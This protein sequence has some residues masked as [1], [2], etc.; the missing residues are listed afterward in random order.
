MRICI[1]KSECRTEQT[2]WNKVKRGT[3]WVCERV[4]ETIRNYWMCESVSENNRYCMLLLY[5][6]IHGALCVY[7]ASYLLSMFE[8]KMR[9]PEW[10]IPVI[11]LM[12]AQCSVYETEATFDF[13]LLSNH[14]KA[15][16]EKM[17]KKKEKRKKIYN[18]KC[19]CS[20]VLSSRRHEFEGF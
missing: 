2:P 1:M 11:L 18:I 14:S 12:H 20:S 17:K 10:Y 3:E 13:K 15:Y 19:V 16:R 5:L 7:R 9:K 6:V 4:R 8:R